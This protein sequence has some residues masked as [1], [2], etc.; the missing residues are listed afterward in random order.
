MVQANQVIARLLNSLAADSTVTGAE[1]DAAVASAQ[2]AAVAAQQAVVAAQQAQLAAQLEVVNARKAITDMLDFTTDALN[3][4]QAQMNIDDLKKQIDDARR[5]LG[6]LTSPN[7][8]YYQ[9]QVTQAQDAFTNAQQD[10][11]LVDISQLQVELRNAQTNLE[12]ATN[13]YNNAK[14]GFAKCPNC[15]TVWAYDRPD[16][17]ADAQ[18]LYADA[19]NLVQQ[20]QTQIDQTQRGARSRLPPRKTT[21]IPP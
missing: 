4:A 9:D 3:L 12:T 7:L 21:W 6:Y 11:R 20:I 2:E 5:N 16:Q 18:N 10:A 1:K 19:V 13:V 17:L 14:D 15:E 8:K